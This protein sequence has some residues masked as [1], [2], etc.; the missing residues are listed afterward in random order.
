MRLILLGPP[1]AGK[2]TQASS[3]VKKYQIP[4]IS[5]GDIFRKNIKEGTELGKKA[6]EY[7][8]KGLLV[9]DD[10]VVAIVK[11]RLTEEDCKDGFL[12]D[13][14]PRTVA[15]ADVLDIEL[16]E[17]S[18]SLDD[19]INIDVS[20]E[21]LIER[22]VGRRVCK[23]CGA[24]FHIKFNSP[25][26]EGICDV[27]SGELQQRKDDTVE[28]VTKRIEVYL[29]QTQPLINYYEN[30]GILINIDGKQEIDKVF[31]DIVSAIGSDK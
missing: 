26:I 30:K 23:D 21:E 29:E 7:M 9:P 5:T 31:S 11:D 6:K 12:L 17:L 4:H 14:F 27:C 3:I 15:Q 25:K 10:L 19:V 13:G 1:G 8:D 20:K 24:T 22:A 18:Y 28:T 2:G 16:R